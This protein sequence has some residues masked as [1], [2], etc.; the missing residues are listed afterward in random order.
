MSVPPFSQ[1]K[2]VEVS[3][4][5]Q[6]QLYVDGSR[7]HT[8]EVHVL[9]F[10]I[11]SCNGVKYLK[12]FKV[13]LKYL[14]ITLLFIFLATFTSLHSKTKECTF[15]SIHFPWH[16]KVLVIF[17]KENCPIHTLIK[18]TSL[19]IPTALDVADS[20]NTNSLFEKWCLSV[21]LAICQ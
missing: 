14:Y 6:D 3:L 10:N 2:S 12:Y 1:F 13:L 18:R 11:S 21:P 20:L 4:C 5:P 19:V 7:V 8:H 9:S 16:Q 15:Y 17:W